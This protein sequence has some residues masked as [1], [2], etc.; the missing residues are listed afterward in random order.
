[1]PSVPH[2]RVWPRPA[3]ACLVAG[4]VAVL[5][6]CAGLASFVPLGPGLLLFLIAVWFAVP[7]VLFGWLVYDQAPGRGMASLLVG[8]VWGYGVSSV[9]LLVLWIAGV[10]GPVLLVAPAMALLLLGFVGLRLRGLL[11]PPAFRW[12]DAV[13]VCLLVV[14][15]VGIVARPFA[16]VG[17]SLPDGGKA[18]RAYFTADFIWRMA[19][20]AELAKGDVPPRNPFHRGE[21]LNY[22]WLAH[23]L[24]A[25]EYREMRRTVT[26]EQILLVNSLALDVAFIA[27]LYGFARQWVRS[28][29]AVS[30]G[31]VGA[32]LFSSFEGAERMWFLWRA[33]APFDL[34]RTLN[35]DAVTRWIYGSLPVD[36]LHRV[37]WYQ[38]HHAMG[39]ALGLSAVL[40]IVQAKQPTAPRLYA[41][42]GTLL[43]LCLLL[44]TFSA[45]M[46]TAITCVVA[47][48]YIV[49]RRAWRDVLPAAIA[50]A[51]PLGAAAA[52]ALS[53]E[54]V[55][56]ASGEMV[57]LLVNPMAVTEAP[58]AILLSF[59]PML[60]VAAVG[61]LLAV[62][63]G[64]RPFGAI[65][66]IVAVSFAFYFFVDLR[67]HQYVYVGWRAGHLL[68]VA[69]VVLVGYAVQQ[70]M[71][72]G[73]AVRSATA[74][75]LTV[76]A[77]LAAPT[78]AI[79]LYNTQDIDNRMQ[80]PGFR[81]TLVLEPEEVEALTWLRKLTP[82]EAI[83]QVDPFTRD[84]ETWA[85]LP[86][87]AER[88]MAAGLP[89]SMIPLEK[90]EA[91]SERVREV[92]RQEDAERAYA[93]A[94]PL[95]IDY[96]FIGAP[97]R[98]AHPG[99]EDALR[100]RPDLFQPVFQ[101]GSVSIYYL[102]RFGRSR[103]LTSTDVSR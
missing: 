70:L 51:V 17:E 101:Q 56:P 95:R 5:A 82:P 4:L 36:G 6:V 98:A 77:L 99:L 79:D 22:Y 97:E 91:A 26:I 50:G 23:L 27:F 60:I 10:R 71:A 73:R 90:Y 35:I 45:I 89:I 84:A 12:S 37:L 86:A 66:A 63:N 81:W 68:F 75:A 8:P 64:V 78:F 41:M 43:G 61:L 16:R 83:V 31:C 38:P 47:M 20:A 65:V 14:L 49:A 39:Y 67:G 24:P 72:H 94:A 32:L 48:G 76:L 19:V 25:A 96:L 7:G 55:A 54:Y 69:F 2:G 21:S 58:R 102:T 34:L 11:V 59:G 53:M 80:A 9:V 93:A 44:S 87:F 18:Y 33:G 28:A 57:R 92:Y 29:A 88:R 52:A 3:R 74:V 85:Y 100:E 62:R 30:V 13:A 42:C 103:E 40:A 1:M 15:V 46:L